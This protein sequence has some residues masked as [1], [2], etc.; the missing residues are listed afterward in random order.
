MVFLKK[1]KAIGFKS[2][3]TPIDISFTDDMTGVVGPNGSGKSNIVDAIRWV[4]GEKS[5]KNLRG[6]IS[7]DVIFHGSKDKEESEYALVSLTFNNKSRAIKIESDEVTVT[8]KLTR[9]TGNNEYFLNDE[10]CRLKEINEVFLDTGLSKGSLGIISQGTV[11]W[12]AEAKPEERRKIF[13]DA[14]GIGLYAKKKIESEQQ[15][16]KANENL[17]RVTD[18]VNTL[19]RDIKKLSKQVEKAKLFSEKKQQLTEL[20]LII[21]IKD[22][23]F[24]QDKLNDIKNNFQKA[25]ADLDFHAN[26]MKILDEQV[27]F[28]KNKTNSSDSI[29]EELTQKYSDIIEEINKIEIKKSA[30]ESQLKNDLTS[31]NVQKKTEA[32][33]QIISSYKFELDDTSSKLSRVQ[34]ELVGFN[35]IHK[36]LLAKREALMNESNVELTK[37]NE[38]RY[39]LKGVIDAI[40]SDMR[41]DFGTKTVLEN[42]NILRGV[43]GTLKQ[44]LTVDEKYERAIS[45]ALGKASNFLIC[46][47]EDSAKY[48]IEFLKK[49]KAGK[50]TFLP[51]N[52]IQPKS[53]RSEHELVMKQL[54]GYLGLAFNLI[55]CED[56]YK[57]IF[58]SFLSRVIIAHDLNT[59]TTI[60]KY[61]SYA[62]QIISLEGDVIAT[63]GAITGGFQRQSFFNALNFK[64]KKDDL[65]KEINRLVEIAEKKRLNLMSIGGSLSDITYKINEKNILQSR[66]LEKINTTKTNLYRHE[67]EYQQLISSNDYTDKSQT[68]SATEIEKTLS[69]LY[70]RKDKLT[71]ELNINRQIKITNKQVYED[72]EA[73]LNEIREVVDNLK[74]QVAK[75][76]T[77]EIKCLGI[78]EKSKDRIANE[79]HMTI[80]YA[81]A[82]YSKELP[83]SETQA[84]DT[85]Y[86]L[87]SELEQM[88]NINMEALGELEDKEK[89]FN[90]LQKQQKELAEAQQKIQSAITELNNKAIHDLSSVVTKVNETLPS[91]FKYLFGGGT[92]Q[93]EYTEPTNILNSGIEVYANPPGKKIGNLNLLSGGEKTMVA[94][95]ILFA[96]LKTHAFPLVILDEAESA[97]DPANVER[98]GNIIKTNSGSTQF[99]IITH[100]PGTMERCHALYGA[101]MQ[102]KGVTNLFKVTL[103][104]AKNEFGEEQK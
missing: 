103:S 53:I 47:N 76:E 19:D 80:E 97:L 36:D 89:E 25:K 33:K 57:N 48:A 102:T 27:I 51:I 56:L 94:L 39:Q 38:T 24:Y 22:V 11:Q 60:A 84:R 41:N 72:N 91:V 87:R 13:E 35:E 31:E 58:S 7:D 85:I 14:A 18:Y 95:S 17:T 74:Y 28:A 29:L 78:L 62:Y 20:D 69:N 37:L 12:F 67:M 43:H 5:N 50:A 86:Q 100:R 2:F 70:T 63:G 52:T 55:Q 64:Q 81:S 45:I 77:D 32:Y 68:W 88:G 54:D 83:M 101:T 99:L 3:A 92:C 82:N 46:D 79:Y 9:G 65:E 73:R 104:H 59:A 61:T 30:I 8:R 44:F 15:L 23:N 98:F 96:I 90:D 40:E 16:L 42:A 49:N 21:L 26:D 34:D 10:P 6:K 1:F 75:N 4:L 71:E 93:I 66:F